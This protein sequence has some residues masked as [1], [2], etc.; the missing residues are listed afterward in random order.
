MSIFTRKGQT[1]ILCSD[2]EDP[3]FWVSTRSRTDSCANPKKNR[4]DGAR[5]RDIIYSQPKFSEKLFGDLDI[6]LQL[7]LPKELGGLFF[8]H[9]E[10]NIK[11]EQLF[12]KLFRRAVTGLHGSKRFHSQI[13][14]CLNRYRRMDSTPAYRIAVS[15]HRWF[16]DFKSPDRDPRRVFKSFKG[17]ISAYRGFVTS[18]K[19]EVRA[20]NDPSD[21]LFRVQ[22]EGRGYSFTRDKDIAEMFAGRSAHHYGDLTDP[23]NTINPTELSD[24]QKCFDHFYRGGHPTIGEFEIAKEDV[25][26]LFAN[27]E[28]E[29]MTFPEKAH[30]KRYSFLKSDRIHESYVNKFDYDFF[31]YGDKFTVDPEKFATF[32]RDKCPPES[33]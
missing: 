31:G 9:I 23:L 13:S 29:V 11:D 17:P 20:S 24:Y 27:G 16:G 1:I 15:T 8:D 6:W 12:W 18:G 32:W 7:Y 2:P 26:L 14:E 28:S 30:L 19:C 22:N 10:Q 5:L 25:I 4:E 3:D 33:E 21:E